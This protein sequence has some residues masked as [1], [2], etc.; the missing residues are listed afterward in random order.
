MKFNPY[1]LV[2]LLLTNAIVHAAGSSDLPDIG[3]SSGSVISPEFER[4]LGRVFM[5]SVR[6]FTTIIDDPEVESYIQ[7]IGYKLVA[8]STDNS[9]TFTFFVVDAPDINAFAAPGGVI[10]VNSGTILNTRNESELAGVLAH[11]ISHVTQRHMARQFE[12]AGQFSLPRTAALLGAILIGISNPQA[13]AAALSVVTGAAAQAQINFTRANE[14]EAD[15]V[16]MQ[17]LAR[18]DYDPRGMVGFFERLQQKSEY[19]TGNAP[20]FLRTHPLTSSRIADSRARASQYDPVNYINTA[21]YGLIRSK[22]EVNNYKNAEEAV[23]EFK[24]RLA[25]TPIIDKIPVRYGYVLALTKA[26][27]YQLAREQLK[28][29]LGLDKDN[30]AYILAAT[31]IESEERKYDVAINIY[32]EAYK[33]YPDYR[34]LVFAYAKTLLDSQLPIQAR[35]LLHHYRR[36]QEADPAYYNLLSQAEAQSGSIAN[37]GIAKAEYH[38]LTGN[39]QQAIDKLIQTKKND[40]LDYYQKESISARLSQLEYELELEKEL[41]I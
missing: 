33:N 17:L 9:L 27:S 24:N 18:S 7:S 40:S 34:P 21:S 28:T 10:G 11:E 20:E 14:K 3:D 37:S 13:G 41:Q 8:N 31:K 1:I 23:R 30:I 25:I 29:L 26:G 35:E 5:R 6:Q 2:F 19:Y 12:Q 4:H 22:I 38:Y 16:G 15:S 32:Q 39:T 36:Q